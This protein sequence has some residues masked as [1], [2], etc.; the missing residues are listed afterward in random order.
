MKETAKHLANRPAAYRKY[1]IYIHPAVV[2][3][4]VE[5]TIFDKRFR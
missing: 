3:S 2:E 5:Q 4:Y 1:Y